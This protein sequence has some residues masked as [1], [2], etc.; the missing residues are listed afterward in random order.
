M[1]ADK[2]LASRPA[3]DQIVDLFG[4]AVIDGN[5]I[6]TA[7]DIECQVFAHDGE[8]DQAEIALCVVVHMGSV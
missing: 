3:V 2:V 4:G 8:A 5:P 1:A 6:A 7:F